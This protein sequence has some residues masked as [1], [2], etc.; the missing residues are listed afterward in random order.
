MSRLRQ[1]TCYKLFSAKLIK[2]RNYSVY[3]SSLIRL[4]DTF[5]DFVK[6]LTGE[7]NG[8]LQIFF[9]SSAKDTWPFPLLQEGPRLLPS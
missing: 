4:Q 2:S 1:L 5:V 3:I 8:I 9:Y 7:Q 6:L